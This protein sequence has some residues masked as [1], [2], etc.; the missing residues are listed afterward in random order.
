MF[1][2]NGTVT[3]EHSEQSYVKNRAYLTSSFVLDAIKL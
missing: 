1:I 3:D 2:R